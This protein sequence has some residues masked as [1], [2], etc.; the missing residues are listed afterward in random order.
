MNSESKKILKRKFGNEFFYSKEDFLNFNDKE[1]AKSYINKLKGLDNKIKARIVE[2]KS[3]N[4]K[5]LFIIYLDENIFKKIESG[6][7]KL[8]S[9]KEL[10]EL[11]T[12]YDLVSENKKLN[13]KEKETKKITKTT[14]VKKSDIKLEKTKTVNYEPERYFES[15]N[16]V[17]AYLFNRITSE[18]Q[19]IMKMGIIKI[20]N[21]SKK[22]LKRYIEILRSQQVNYDIRIKKE[23]EIIEFMEEQAK[24]LNEYLLKIE[25]KEAEAFIKEYIIEPLKNGKLKKFIDKLEK[26]GINETSYLILKSLKGKI[27]KFPYSD[28]NLLKRIQ[29]ILEDYK[30]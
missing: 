15:I 8:P 11:N 1:E 27:K 13:V 21:L 26:N 18:A 19:K 28:T 10:N 16:D 29:K 4:G 17:P 14:K 2:K 12:K 30:K 20:E 25:E 23:K 22:K 3:V 7:F 6:D 24:I 5:I 9:I